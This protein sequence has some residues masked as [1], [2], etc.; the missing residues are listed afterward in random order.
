VTAAHS[1]L[2]IITVISP[3][4]ASMGG[5]PGGIGYLAEMYEAANLRDELSV[6]Q[7]TDRWLFPSLARLRRRYPGRLRTRWVN[8]HSFLGLYLAVRFHIRSYPTIMIGSEIVDSVGGAAEFEEL[9]AA[10]LAAQGT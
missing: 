7:Q 2:L 3:G 8:P 9:I 5:A 6:R 4:S 1:D 10:R